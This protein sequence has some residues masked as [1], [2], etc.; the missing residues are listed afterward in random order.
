MIGAR[1]LH[2]E[3]TGKLGEGGM[4]IVYKARDTHLNRFVALKI[5]PP[6]RLDD[7][8]RKCRFIQEAKASSALNHPNIVTI[9]DFAHEDGDLMPANAPRFGRGGDLRRPAFLRR[10]P[11]AQAWR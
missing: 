8:D 10:R 6:G 1:L 5:L 7:P 9:H 3:I 4:G 2:Y 11:G